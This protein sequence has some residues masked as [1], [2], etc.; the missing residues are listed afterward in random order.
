MGQ[1][2]EGNRRAGVGRRRAVE[3]CAAGFAGARGDIVSARAFQAG[4]G[5]CVI[6]PR[7][8]NNFSLVPMAFR[9]YAAGNRV[10]F[11]VSVFAWVCMFVSLAAAQGRELRFCLHTEPKTFDLLKVED[12]ASVSIR[13]LTGG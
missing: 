2:A 9:R 10:S 8:T 13:Y 4:R 6:G 5:E 12:D 3:V 11:A 1:P 7:T